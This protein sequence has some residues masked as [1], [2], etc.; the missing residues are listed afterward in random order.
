M[1]QDLTFRN[2]QVFILVYNMSQWALL[3]DLTSATFQ[4][5]IRSDAG[6]GLPLYSFASF[7]RAGIRGSITYEPISQ[8]L[9]ATATYA[10]V[11]GYLQAGVYVHDLT[12]EF[13]DPI[14]GAPIIIRD[15]AAGSLT[16]TDGVTL[17]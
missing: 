3:Y 14:S 2:N 4:M 17:R 9:T 5:Q 8:L 16:V 12:L 7:V 1:S 10:D 11:R 13:D 6:S 15:V